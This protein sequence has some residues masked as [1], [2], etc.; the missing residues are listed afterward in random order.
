MN[1]M[2]ILVVASIIMGAVGLAVFLWSFNSRQ[3][4]DMDGAAERVLIDDDEV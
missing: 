2:I 3:Y 1:V 4:D